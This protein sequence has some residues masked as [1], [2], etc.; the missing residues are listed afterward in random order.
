ML[1]ISAAE[2]AAG[3][4]SAGIWPA[5]T[6]RG[7]RGAAWVALASILSCLPPWFLGV[8]ELLGLGPSRLLGA[9]L[10][11]LGASALLAL[12]LGGAV[13]ASEGASARWTLTLLLGAL[14]AWAGALQGLSRA[15]GVD[16]LAQVRALFRGDR[17]GP[18]GPTTPAPSPA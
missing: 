15:L 14:L 1:W 6:L 12:V 7:L 8:R 5:T 17:G 11:G 9:L 13:L 10:P 16:L 4:V 2:V 3:L 18:S